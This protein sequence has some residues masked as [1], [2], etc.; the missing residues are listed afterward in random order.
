[1]LSLPSP[2]SPCRLLASVLE[3]VPIGWLSGLA[4]RGSFN[5]SS[6][7]AWGDLDWEVLV[8]Y[9]EGERTSAS[10]VFGVS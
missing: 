5:W 10:W 6:G 9:F 1:M 4:V 8:V 7:Q 3:A 2:S